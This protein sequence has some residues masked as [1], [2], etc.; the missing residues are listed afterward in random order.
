MKHLILGSA[1]QIGGH[2]FDYLRGKGE[3]VF[4]FDIKNW[5][6]E[7]LRKSDN[8][9]LNA[10]IKECDFVY[11]LAFDIGGSK[12]LEQYQNSYGFI[13][14]NMKIMV[15]TFELINKNQKPFIFASSQMADMHHST[16]GLLKAIGEKITLDLGGV[17]TRFWN[18]Y[19]LEKDM[20]KSHVITDF[21]RMAVDDKHIKMRTTGDEARQFLYA[22][23][24]AKCL[25]EIAKNYIKHKGQSYD[26]TNFEW[27]K[28]KE[29]AEIIADLIWADITLGDKIDN[30]QLNAMNPPR[31]D[32]LE[33]WK[34]ETPLREGIQK[35]IDKM[36]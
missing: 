2:L 30:V 15:N 4:T 25:F 21:I 7:D 23:D 29:V 32:I 6:Y 34:P 20:K 3:I 35:I 19:G 22:T 10:K 5:E 12:Y 27:N 28:I 33:F 13:M 24:C 26:V 14:N 17:I 18:V 31:K 36:K 16:Y 1:G 8:C 9:V 11:F